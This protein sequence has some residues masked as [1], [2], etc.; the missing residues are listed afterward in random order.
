MI[1]VHKL[2]GHPYTFEDKGEHIETTGAKGPNLGKKYK[3]K[4]LENFVVK[5]ASA[6]N[7]MSFP[8]AVRQAWPENANV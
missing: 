6:L 3:V 1:L 2:S 4:S 5:P 8:G 7:R